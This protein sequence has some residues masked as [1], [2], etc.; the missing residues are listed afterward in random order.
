MSR[1][2]TAKW[3]LIAGLA[4]VF[5]YFGIDKFLHPT[6]WVGWIPAFMDGLLGM[7]KFLWLKIIGVTE[8]VI[9]VCL[10]LPVRLAQQIAIIV[11]MVQLVTI[12]W[13]G[14]WN[15]I[16]VRDSGLLCSLIAL[17]YLL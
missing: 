2:S 15:D 11:G 6:V 5:G 9:A 10:M 4:F 12:I 17:F 16:A 14:G 13:I 3:T 8:I 1:A 7:D